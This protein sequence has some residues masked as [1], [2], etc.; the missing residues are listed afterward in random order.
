MRKQPLYAIL[1]ALT[2]AFAVAALLTLVPRDAS[3]SCIL[4]YEA[5]CSFTPASTV[6]LLALGGMT[7][8]VRK[9]AAYYR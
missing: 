9:R 2:V 8:V 6:M 4:G 5:L 3:G 7:C 1:L